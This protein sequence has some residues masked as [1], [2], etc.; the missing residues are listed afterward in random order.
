MS[1][2]IKEIL[3]SLGY[4]LYD[5]GKFWQTNA[6]FRDGDNKTAVQIYKDTG[7]WKDHVQDTNFMKFEVL[8]KK[9]L[10]TNNELEI[11]KYLKGNTFN[12]LENRK[13]PSQRIEMEKTFDKDILKELLP[14]YKFYNDKGISN[15]VLKFFK[16]GFS[17]YGAMHKRFVFPIFNINNEIHGLAGRDMISRENRPKWK[18]VGKKSNWI[19]PA[20]LKN[21]DGKNIASIIEDRKEV[22]LVESIGDLLSLHENGYKN[23]LVTF[24]LEISPALICFLSSIS[25]KKI[26]LSFN[27]DEDKDENRGLNACIKNYLKLLKVFDPNIIK[28]CLPTKNDFGEMSSGDYEAWVNKLNKVNDSNQQSK[29]ISLSNSLFKK[30][31]L[32]KTIMNNLKYING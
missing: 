28:I 19:Y 17:T 15:S 29:I 8:V 10:G 6:L 5:R 24:G 11:K 20:Y 27:N 7:V 18:H 3:E 16:S 1:L 31:K 26:I 32:S 22:I 9:T 23:V 2:E 13:E 25:L 12:S 4:K 14:H 30:G 21:K